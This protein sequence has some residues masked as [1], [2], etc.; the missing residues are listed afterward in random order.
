MLLLLSLLYNFIQ[1]NLKRSSAGSNPACG[2]PEIRGGEDLWQWTQLEIRLNVFC[3]STIPQKQFIIIIIS[4]SLSSLSSP[5]PTI[6]F[7]F[8]AKDLWRSFVSLQI[9]CKCGALIFRDI[10]S[11]LRIQE[12]C[13]WRNTHITDALITGSLELKIHSALIAVS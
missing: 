9:R 10:Y 13:S 5:T 1:L 12:V 2:V 8:F 11:K 7:P 3:R 6:K 4:S